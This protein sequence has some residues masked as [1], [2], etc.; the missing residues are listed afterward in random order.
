M[1]Y[2]IQSFLLGV[3]KIIV[4]FRD[5]DGILRNVQEFQTISI[6]YDVQRRGMAKWDGNVCIRFTSLFLDCKPPIPALSPN[7]T[8]TD[9]DHY[10][11]GLRLSINDEGV[12]RIK[13]ARGTDHIE[14]FRVEEAG[15][16]NIITD[17]FMNWRIKLDLSRSKPPDAK[18]PAAREPT[19]EQQPAPEPA[20]A[21]GA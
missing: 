8:H 1:K 19:P 16:G 13:R 5:R 21:S 11:T 10:H 4:G 15:H 18:S 6:P 7:S 20:N 9:V 14:I 12:W 2:W 17:E 3:P